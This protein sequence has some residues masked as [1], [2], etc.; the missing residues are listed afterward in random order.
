MRH[1]E[2][3][4]FTLLHLIPSPVYNLLAFPKGALLAVALGFSLFFNHVM[5]KCFRLQNPERMQ[6]ITLCFIFYIVLGA[7]FIA[8]ILFITEPGAMHISSVNV[9]FLASV[10]GG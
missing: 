9:S 1:R 5:H 3:K 8:L 2:G 4:Y 6:L 7:S 10:L